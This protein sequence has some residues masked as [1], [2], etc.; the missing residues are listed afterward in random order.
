MMKFVSVVLLSLLMAAP[1]TA[2]YVFYNK[3]V[4]EWTATCWRDMEGVNKACRLSAPPELL[5]PMAPQN[6]LVVEEISNDAYRVTIEVRDA[7]VPTPGCV[8]DSKMVEIPVVNAPGSLK[9][10]GYGAGFQVDPAAVWRNLTVLD[11]HPP[12]LLATPP[13][14]LALPDD[15]MDADLFIA[16]AM[17]LY[18]RHSAYASVAEAFRPIPRSTLSHEITFIVP[19]AGMDE[20]GFAEKAVRLRLS[21][22]KKQVTGDA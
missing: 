16:V 15:W 2:A 4:G 17:R 12:G 14:V 19:D 8:G 13:F 6:V 9:D 3:E 11:P 7:V 20:R 10:N 5:A 1:A 18:R 21:L 22:E